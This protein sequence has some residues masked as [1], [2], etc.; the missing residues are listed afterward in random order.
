LKITKVTLLATVA[1][2]AALGAFFLMAFR[3]IPELVF[4]AV[5]VP[6]TLVAYWVVPKMREKEAG[7]RR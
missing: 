5:I 6:C 2:V 7:K 4:W 3:V 1:L